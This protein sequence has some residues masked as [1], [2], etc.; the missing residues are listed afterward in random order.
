MTQAGLDPYLELIGLPSEGEVRA[1]VECQNCHLVYR[2]P[3]LTQEELTS[4]Y[5]VF[6]NFMLESETPD[7]Y[8]E[9]I[10]SLPRGQSE[11]EDKLDWICPELIR[12]FGAAGPNKVLD[13]GCGGGVFLWSLIKRF[14]LIQAVGVEPTQRFADLTSRRLGIVVHAAQFKAG[15]LRDK[16]DA[17]FLNQVLEHVYASV[18]FM[19]SVA[20]HLGDNGVVYVEVPSTADIGIL[21]ESHDRFMSQHLY[22][23]S[24]ATLCEVL[25]RAGLLPVAIG[26][27]T[28][29][30]GKRNVMVIARRNGEAAKPISPADVVT[31]AEA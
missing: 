25:N 5:H 8:F 23:F 10:T 7:Q 13:I 3:R 4:L 28:T 12:S 17:I 24:E 26:S 15:L 29:R 11:N 14:P 6:R 18:A 22:I 1:I 2:R 19:R 27:Q 30:R 21:P 20:E 31:K 16:F 9:R